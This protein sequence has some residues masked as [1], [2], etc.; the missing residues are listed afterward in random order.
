[1]STKRKRS[2]ALANGPKACP[3]KAAFQKAQELLRQL[4]DA[5]DRQWQFISCEIH[6]GLAQR[7]AGALMQFE[8]YKTFKDTDPRLAAKAHAIGV[9]LVQEGNAEAR[10]LIGALRPPQ[11]QGSGAVT[12]IR[13]LVERCKERHNIKI[14]FRSHVAKLKLAPVL[15]NA[16]FRIVQEC[17]TNACRHSKSK[18]VKVELT[19]HDEQ[20]RIEVRDWGVGFRMDRVGEG[21]FGLV[22]IQERAEA[23]G[24]HAVITSSPGK[25]TTIVVELPRHLPRDASEKVRSMS[26]VQWSEALPSRVHIASNHLK[27]LCGRTI[28]GN[29]TD[30]TEPPH[31][32][33]TVCRVCQRRIGFQPVD[34]KGER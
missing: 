25:G 29:A 23:F 2:L 9:R 17:L 5:G 15:E 22:G 20:L 30:V 12:A 6:D 26:F 7:L 19:Q 11:L 21:H 24:G 27:T 4:L 8:A 31:D 13:R 1:M 33:S 14:E 10:R 28:P 16:V 34:P 3:G 32:K 18:K